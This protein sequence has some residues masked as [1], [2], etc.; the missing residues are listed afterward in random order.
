MSTVLVYLKFALSIV[1]C[2]VLLG[3]TVTRLRSSWYLTGLYSTD[4]VM[5]RKCALYFFFLIMAG[6]WLLLLPPTR[7]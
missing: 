3:W 7:H 4:P 5:F 2:A 1:P 6:G